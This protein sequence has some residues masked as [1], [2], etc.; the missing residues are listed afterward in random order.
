MIYI[1]YLK[2]Y[3]ITLYFFIINKINKYFFKYSYYKNNTQRLGNIFEVF[4]FKFIKIDI[5]YINQQ[6]NEFETKKLKIK[7]LELNN[8][9]YNILS[10]LYY[11]LKNKYH[12][13]NNYSKNDI[14]F[15][16]NYIEN[17][18][19]SFYDYKIIKLIYY[20]FRNNFKSVIKEYMKNNNI[21]STKFKKGHCLLHFRVGDFIKINS[22]INSLTKLIDA[23][24]YISEKIE[25]IEIMN[26][27]KTYRSNYFDSYIILLKIKNLLKIKFKNTKIIF[28]NNFNNSDLDL[29]YMIQA[30]I[31]VTGPGSF[32]TI[33]NILSDAHIKISPASKSLLYPNKGQIQSGIFIEND[34]SNWYLYNY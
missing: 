18:G 17:Y 32:A 33:A 10:F 12:I 25:I 27:G 13:K 34:Y 11:K 21:S 24:D 23:F 5:N 28:N 20:D 7:E 22:N 16:K 15:I 9:N 19:W 14:V 30:P 29:I 31:L 8:Q 4:Y 1:L 2:V 26:S 6:Y 3:I